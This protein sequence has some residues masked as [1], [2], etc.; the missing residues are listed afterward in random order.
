[1]VFYTNYYRTPSTF[2]IA[3]LDNNPKMDLA[4]SSFDSASLAPCALHV[5]LTFSVY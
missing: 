3:Q 5:M 1:M 4:S 2:Q